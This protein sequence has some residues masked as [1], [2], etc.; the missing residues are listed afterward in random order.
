MWAA[1]GGDAEAVASLYEAGACTKPK[2]G[3]W[4]PLMIAAR[5]GHHEVVEWLLAHGA[6]HGSKNHADQTAGDLAHSAGHAKTAELLNRVGSINS[7][8][9]E[10]PRA[11]A[12]ARACQQ[13]EIAILRR[14]RLQRD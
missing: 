5:S 12:R 13:H 10:S 9:G 14:R 3:G 1:A 4:D 8:H 7:W 6:P 11:R 2:Q